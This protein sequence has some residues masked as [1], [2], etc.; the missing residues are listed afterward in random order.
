[1]ANELTLS[2]SAAYLDSNGVA[3]SLGVTGLNVSVG[4]KGL[5]HLTQVIPTSETAL[6]LGSIGTL[7]YILCRNNDPTNYVEF[8]TVA[9]GTV[10]A[11]LKP[12][13]MMLFRFGSGITAPVAI[14]NT[15]SCGLEYILF[16]A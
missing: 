15:A 14:A 2:S 12:G 4:T 3:D 5:A 10:F 16:N 13:E 6:N 7:G 8:K 11:K 9:S 1:M